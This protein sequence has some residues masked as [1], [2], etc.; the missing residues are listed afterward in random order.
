MSGAAAAVSTIAA[1]DESTLAPVVVSAT[2]LPLT[3]TAI[4][5]RVQV[6]T[7]SFPATHACHWG[8]RRNPRVD[9]E[10]DA[11]VFHVDMDPLKT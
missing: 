6:F 8:Y 1:Q 9:G 3:E 11:P 5:H 2:G 4:N 7:L 10:I